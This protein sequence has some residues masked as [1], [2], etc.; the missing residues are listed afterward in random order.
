MITAMRIMKTGRPDTVSASRAM[1]DGS[2]PTAI[3]Y[4]PVSVGLMYFPLGTLQSQ[5]ADGRGH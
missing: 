2:C 3:D 1:E 4:A 5:I